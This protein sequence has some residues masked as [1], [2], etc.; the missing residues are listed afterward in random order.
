MN[1]FIIMNRKDAAVWNKGDTV[2]KKGDPPE[3]AYLVVTGIV[4]FFSEDGVSLGTAGTDEVFGE[5]S[6]YLNRTHSVTA[7]AKTNLVAKKI[8]KRELEKIISKTHPVIMGML[9]STYHRLADSNIKS[10]DYVKEINKYSL[11]FEKSKEDSE[12]LK[13]RIDSIKEK[14]DKVNMIDSNREKT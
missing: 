3:Y 14:L 4:E 2:Y 9:R 7:K 5:I 1:K 13:N 12:N 10:E 11:M 6:C 8:F